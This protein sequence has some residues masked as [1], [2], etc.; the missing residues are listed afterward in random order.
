MPSKPHRSRRIVGEQLARG[1]ARHPVDLVVG[2]H[3][4]PQ[5]GSGHGRLERERNS[6]FS[7]RCPMWDGAWLRPP[8]GRPW[9]TM[10]LP[11]AYD[12]PQARLWGPGRRGRRPNRARRQDTDPRRRSPRSAPAWIA[13]DVEDRRE[14]LV[15]A[16]GPQLAPE[17]VG[18]GLD[19]LR[20][21]ARG[22]ADRLREADRRWQA[23]RA[24]D[25]SWTMAGIPSRVSSR[26]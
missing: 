13:R 16:H 1:D 2:V 3:H 21:P 24:G 11:V 5:P 22:L 20:L 14:R 17:P 25:S 9:P 18:H 10:C 6:S 15:R 7:S 23:A 19:E 12:H 26:R 8:S 4:R